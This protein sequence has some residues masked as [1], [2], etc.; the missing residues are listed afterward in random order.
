MDNADLEKAQGSALV[1][2]DV[3]TFLPRCHS[4]TFGV[5]TLHFSYLYNVTTLHF[6]YKYNVAT[7][8]VDVATDDAVGVVTLE[9]LSSMLQPYYDVATLLLVS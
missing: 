8:S 7:L 2:P 4:C 9:L 1:A 3:V 5:V 6:A